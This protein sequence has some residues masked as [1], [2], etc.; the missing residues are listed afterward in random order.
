MK[1]ICLIM[2]GCADVAVGRQ[3]VCKRVARVAHSIR[4]RVPVML[5]SDLE[6]VYGVGAKISEQSISH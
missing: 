1:C 6:I 5:G 4:R 2:R 3:A